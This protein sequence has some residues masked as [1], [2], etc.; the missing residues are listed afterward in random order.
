M[1]RCCLKGAVIRQGMQLS[2]SW[3]AEEH[4]HKHKHGLDSAILW[5]FGF[6]FDGVVSMNG[7]SCHLS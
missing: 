4:K 5:A 3:V 6:N 7:L 2:Q 1:N